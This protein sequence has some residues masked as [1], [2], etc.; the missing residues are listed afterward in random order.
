MGNTRKGLVRLGAAIGALAAI[1]GIISLLYTAGILQPSAPDPTPTPLPTPTPTPIAFP[2]PIPTPTTFV[3]SAANFAGQWE[4]LEGSNSIH[5][6]PVAMKMVI[7]QQ[8]DVLQIDIYAG[9]APGDYPASPQDSGSG[10]VSGGQVTIYTTEMSGDQAFAE[11]QWVLSLPSPGTLHFTQ[12]KHY[13]PAFAEGRSDWDA[14][15]DLHQS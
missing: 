14:S 10:T 9:N 3:P 6:A 12:H 2:T 15:G 4:G 7:T 8:G 13:E 1:A 11:N 5:Q